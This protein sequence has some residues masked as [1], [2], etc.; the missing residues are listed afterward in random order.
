MTLLDL[1]NKAGGIP[2]DSIRLLDKAWLVRVK[3]DYSRSFI[4][5]NIEGVL[6]DASHPDNFILR[7]KDEVQITYVRDYSSE[8]MVSIGGAVRNPFEMRYAAGLNVRSLVEMA[9]GLTPY[10][11]VSRAF[12]IRTDTNY[13]R[14]IVELDLTD[15]LSDSMSV[16]NVTLE[17]RDE[18]Q[19]LSKIDRRAEEMV[20]IGGAV[21]NPLEIMWAEGLKVSDLVELAG[22]IRFETYDGKLYLRRLNDDLT[23]SI[24]NVNLAAILE[25]ASSPENVVLRPRDE[26]RVIEKPNVNAGLVITVQGEVRTPFEYP[27]SEGMTLGEALRL[28]GGITL[29]ADYSRIEVSR[30]SVFSDLRRGALKDDIRSTAIVAQVPREFS[31]N[32]DAYSEDM[33]FILQPYD[34]IMVREIPEFQLQEFVYIGGEVK[35]PGYY[36]LESRED[37]LK[38]LIRRAGGITRYADKGNASMT[39]EG[40]PNVVLNFKRAMRIPWSTYNYVLE[41]GDQINVPRT[42]SLISITGPGHEHFQKTF[43]STL[44]SPLSKY[45]RAGFYVN[46]YAGGFYKDAKRSRTYVTYPNG[47]VSRTVNLYVAQIYP[48]VKKGA[49]IHTVLEAPEV[50][51]RKVAR[52]RRDPADWN[53][54]ISDVVAQVS[55][56]VTSIGYFYVLV[57]R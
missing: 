17:P 38:T 30:L 28:A 25:D 15:I 53:T 29:K 11:D 8:E 37:R 52:I 4:P 12:I 9:G 47:K 2:S 31:R 21:R 14:E 23:S 13:R 10:A 32:L 36:V 7:V 18:L 39:R 54:I 6:K 49:T 27:Y 19:I 20:S 56:A 57:T 45:R 33:D 16:S 50:I 44:S 35:Y 5:V 34:Q 48:R 26:L 24:V 46:K 55:T 41:P 22:G 1:I 51:E 40:Y 43:E 42:R 3:P